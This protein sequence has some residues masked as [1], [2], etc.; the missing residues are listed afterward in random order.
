VLL[1]KAK[2]LTTILV[3]KPSLFKTHPD[4]DF[5]AIFIIIGGVGSIATAA[6]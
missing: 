4:L 3:G 6:A 1:I 5:F 2:D